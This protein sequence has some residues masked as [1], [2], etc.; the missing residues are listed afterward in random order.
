ML[1]REKPGLRKRALNKYKAR[2]RKKERKEV[3]VN[4]AQIK[5]I[6]AWKK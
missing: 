3:N 2:M 6:K 1:R 5:H 4:E